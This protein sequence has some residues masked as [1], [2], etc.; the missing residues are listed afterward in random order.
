MALPAWIQSRRWG[1]HELLE[2]QTEAAT[3]VLS[4][5]GAQV[6]SF[7]PQGQQDLLWW[8]STSLCQQGKPIRGGIP[9]CWPNFADAG[10]PF[11]G[12][13]RTRLWQL[14]HA[15]LLDVGASLSLVP[16]QQDEDKAVRLQLEFGA[17]LS[18]SLTTR[19]LDEVPLSLTQALHSYLRVGDWRQISLHGLDGCL[20][21]DKLAAGTE[22]RQSGALHL[23]EAI[24]AIFQH[25]GA[26]QIRDPQLQRLLTVRKAGS[27]S[28][29][30]WQ[31]GDN[32]AN[33]KDVNAA[34]A[35]HFVCVEAANTL[36]DPVVLQPG[37]E[38]TLQTVL[39]VEGL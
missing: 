32:L 11:H 27:G 13:A 12:T 5:S 33:F 1:E 35:A 19:N 3:L 22:R 20:W 29:V 15:Q 6:L 7:V 16:V 23:A 2:V 38:W 21:L 26:V 34:E 37:Q 30:V 9:L 31:P 28:T 24:D 18:V 25:Q 39:E 36:L 17:R 8:S 4:L 14:E 10:E